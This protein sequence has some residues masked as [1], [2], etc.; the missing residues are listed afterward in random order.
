MLA[1]TDRTGGARSKAHRREVGHQPR[2][3]PRCG[4]SA[5][6]GQDWRTSTSPKRWVRSSSRTS[7]VGTSKQN[8][9]QP[10]PA[11]PRPR[12]RPQT[13]QRYGNDASTH[14]RRTPGSGHA[15]TPGPG[16][17]S[18][19]ACSDAR[20]A[21]RPGPCRRRAA[22]RTPRPR[23]SHLSWRSLSFP[24]SS[25]LLPEMSGKGGTASTPTVM[26]QAARASSI[27]RPG[28]TAG[29]RRPPGKRNGGNHT[30]KH[31][32]R[33]LRGIRRAGPVQPRQQARELAGAAPAKRAGNPAPGSYRRGPDA[34]PSRSRVTTARRRR[35]PSPSRTRPSPPPAASAPNASVAS[36][37]TRPG[38][39][40]GNSTFKC[41]T[42]STCRTA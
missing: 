30:G 23:P 19:A 7:A 34:S 39:P 38:I 24:I 32:R 33:P 36:T 29:S 2:S 15:R 12:H 3:A 35:R 41:G 4:I 31:R 16:S 40:S 20:Q 25:F 17:R 37:A 10:A 14:H 42:P 8:H 1:E 5:G 13:V 18:Q 28:R 6:C 22:A 26:Q 27:L 21:P 11:A 9:Q